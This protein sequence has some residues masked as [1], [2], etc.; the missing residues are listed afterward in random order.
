MGAGWSPDGIAV[1]KM[2]IDLRL[3]LKRNSQIGPVA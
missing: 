2:V 1:P 3:S